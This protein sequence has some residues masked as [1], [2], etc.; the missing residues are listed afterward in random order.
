M[1]VTQ[2]VVQHNNQWI[3]AQYTNYS[4]KP[5]DLIDVEVL[6]THKILRDKALYKEVFPLNALTPTLRNLKNTSDLQAAKLLAR[7]G[8]GKVKS[9]MP[10][11]LA[12]L[13]ERYDRLFDF[14]AIM[15]QLQD[16]DALE[17]V[18]EYNAVSDSV[19]IKSSVDCKIDL[20]HGRNLP[21]KID[22]VESTQLVVYVQSKPAS[23]ESFAKYLPTNV[24]KSLMLVVYTAADLDSLSGWR[25]KSIPELTLGMPNLQKLDWIPLGGAVI[26]KLGLDC[27]K[28]TSLRGLETVS[29]NQIRLAKVAVSES[30]PFSFDGLPPNVERIKFGN[31]PIRKAPINF[32]SLLLSKNPPKL[33][34][35]HYYEDDINAALDAIRSAPRQQRNSVIR[36]EMLRLSKIVPVKWLSLRT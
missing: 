32:L 24:S 11:S 14:Q 33:I 36:Q 21:C 25:F 19:T 20:N 13:I 15:P 30:K 2:A 18:V 8:Y 23:P 9:S 34:D 5:G 29:V 16:D 4:Y 28:L 12:T 10:P 35:E 6:S 3:I 22:S 26:D 7:S 27:Q 1:A 17:Q 31:E